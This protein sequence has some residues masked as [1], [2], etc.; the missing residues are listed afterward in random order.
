MLILEP[1]KIGTRV[2]THLR[3]MFGC[4]FHVTVNTVYGTTP[5]VE[6]QWKNGPCVESVAEALARLGVRAP[7]GCAT[8]RVEKNHTHM[9]FPVDK[10]C[11]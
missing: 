1:Y 10:R 7:N 11:R 5:T 9:N 4:A 2:D 3:F 6:V 8:L